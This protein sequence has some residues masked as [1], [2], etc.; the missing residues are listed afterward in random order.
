MQFQAFCWPGK[1]AEDTT[2]F[3]KSEQLKHW[4]LFAGGIGGGGKGGGGGGEGGEGGGG[5]GRGGGG[6]GGGLAGGD[7]AR[8]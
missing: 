5:G 3:T 1:T 7:G 6:G 8:L 2:P 4:P